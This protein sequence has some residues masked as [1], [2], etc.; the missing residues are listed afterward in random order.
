M[1]QRAVLRQWMTMRCMSDT[2][3][4]TCLMTAWHAHETE[5]QRW[6]TRHLN[7][8]VAAQD[9]LQDVFIKALRQ[10]RRFCDVANARAWLFE[11]SRNTLTDHLRRHHPLDA[12]SDD[13]PAVEADPPAA[14]DSLATCLPRVLAE[15]SASDRDAIVQCDL[16][17]MGQEDYAR[18]LGI[19]VP[20]A[21]SRVQRARKRLRERLLT[22]CQVVLNER[23][24]VC[25]F[26]PRPK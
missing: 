10:G 11:V 9:L 4:P 17:G 2:S 13:L 15:L 19:T 16:N 25:C 8:P 24:A 6:L 3:T 5:L 7:D 21:K 23:G 22:S 14:V 26:T 20:G 18:M 1:E 12:L